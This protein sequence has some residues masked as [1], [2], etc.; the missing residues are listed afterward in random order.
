MRWEK[1]WLISTSLHNGVVVGLTT[2]GGVV[3]GQGAK[4]LSG[5]TKGI[6]P[7]HLRKLKM[8]GSRNSKGDKRDDEEGEEVDGEVEEIRSNAHY[9][10]G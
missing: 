10:H 5:S 6:Y 9:M 4:V 3:L 8:S 1:H 7:R 2:C